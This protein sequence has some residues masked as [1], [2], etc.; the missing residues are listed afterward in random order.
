MKL[1]CLAALAFCLGCTA[2]AN[3][4]G[5]PEFSTHSQLNH[6]NQIQDQGPTPVVPPDVRLI[7]NVLDT[8]DLL[9]NIDCVMELGSLERQLRPLL[10]ASW[11]AFLKDEELK[12]GNDCKKRVAWRSQALAKMHPARSQS[13]HLR[14]ITGQGIADN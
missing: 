1:P 8:T 14:S 13:N 7:Q 5:I 10:G 2:F 3:A 4:Q 11:A 9:A 6:H 12:C